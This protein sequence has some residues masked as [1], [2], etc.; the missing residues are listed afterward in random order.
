VLFINT[1]IN[2]STHLDKIKE[3]NVCVFGHEKKNRCL[4]SRT[5]GGIKIDVCP[6]KKT[7]IF[8]PQK[9]IYFF[10]LTWEATKN[11]YFFSIKH[12]FFFS[13]EKFISDRMAGNRCSSKIAWPPKHIFFFPRKD[14][15]EIFPVNPREVRSSFRNIYFFPDPQKHKHSFLFLVETSTHQQISTTTQQRIMLMCVDVLMC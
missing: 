12:L 2:T 15:S 3:L 7:S 4:V 1:P 11:L 9:N 10:P 5:V 14:F 6:P 13:K 8:F